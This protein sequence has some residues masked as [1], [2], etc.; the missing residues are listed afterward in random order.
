MAFFG[1]VFL[2]TDIIFLFFPHELFDYTNLVSSYLGFIHPFP[3][4]HEK[5]W[6]ILTNAMMVMIT[7]ISFKVAINPVDNMALVPVVLIAKLTSSITALVY[8]FYEDQYFAYL[9]IFIVDFPIFI[10]IYYF[11]LKARRSTR[12][13]S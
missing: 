2:V 3:F 9:L 12:I 6:L 10:A 1:I 4:P 8:F 7:F 13:F 5:F 11:Y